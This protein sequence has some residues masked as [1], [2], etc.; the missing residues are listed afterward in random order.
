MVSVESESFVF[1]GSAQVSR[2][3]F[4]IAAEEDEF[5]RAA[6]AQVAKPFCEL[7]RGELLAGGVEQDDR[8]ARVEFKFAKRGGAS[9]AEFGDFDIGVVADAG[10]VVVE[11]RAGFFAARFAE[12]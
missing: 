4:R 10:G 2:E 1:G 3:A 11:E 7:L 6:V 9:V 8:C 12:H 5:A